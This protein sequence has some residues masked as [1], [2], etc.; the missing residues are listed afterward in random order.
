MIKGYYPPRDIEGYLIDNLSDVPKESEL[1]DYN[2]FYR[3]F[4]NKRTHYIYKIKKPKS[5]LMNLMNKISD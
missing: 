2:E 1:I 5:S 4:K 3:L